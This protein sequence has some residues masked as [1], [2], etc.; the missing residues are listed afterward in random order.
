MVMYRVMVCGDETQKPFPLLVWN[1]TSRQLMYDLRIPFHEFI[2][3]LAAITYEG[4]YVCCVAQ[5]SR[6][7][8]VTNNSLRYLV[9]RHYLAFILRHCLKSPSNGFGL[10][11]KS[12]AVK[13]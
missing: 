6:L 12:T 10:K 11:K 7:L 5:V 1:L 13:L 3:R 2:T 8:K 4:H 9:Y